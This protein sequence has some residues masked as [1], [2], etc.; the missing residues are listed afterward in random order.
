MYACMKEGRIQLVEKIV[1]KEPVVIM[2]E[3][4]GKVEVS[5]SVSLKQE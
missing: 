5:T 1:K 3:V 2:S 4:D